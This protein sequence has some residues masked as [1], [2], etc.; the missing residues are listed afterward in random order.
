VPPVAS[1]VH[2]F[3][4]QGIDALSYEIEVDLCSG[5]LHGMAIVGLPDAAVRESA[6]R[7][8]TA[9]LASGYR[10]PWQRITVSLAP[11]DLRKEGPV[12]DLPIAVALLHAAGVV[13]EEAT[14]RMRELL[15]AGELALDGRLRPI[16]GSVSMALLA[17]RERRRGAVVP[18]A[19]GAEAAA[20]EGVEIHAM[21]TLSEVVALLNGPE[22]FEP[23][24]TIEAEALLR[25]AVAEIDFSEI[26]GQEAAKR[27]LT[28][29][30]AGAHNIL[31]I[32]PAGAG[33]TMMA[34]A[35]PGLLPPM[36]REEALEVTRIHSC[37]GCL[38]G[39]GS[40]VV[41]RPVRSPHHTASTAAIV[42]GGR[43]PRPGEVSL[44]HRG[45]LFL[46]ELPE[47]AR[48]V[49]EGLREPLEDGVVTIAR[50][51]GS[52]R[53][54][55]EVLLVAAMNPTQRGNRRAGAAGARE[56]ERY[57]SR[58]SGPLVDRVD[59]HVE[60]PAVPFEQL[61]GARQGATTETLRERVIGARQRAAARQGPDRPNSALRSRELDAVAPLDAASRSLLGEAMQQFGLSAR[62]YDKIRRVAR[63]IADLDGSESPRLEHVAEAVSYRLLDR[64]G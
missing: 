56:Q 37:A 17:R 34:R 18:L 52:V 2:S 59:L 11:S 48:P 21:G 50:A 57:L 60:V 33:K 44:A 29:A 12:F 58:L 7:V 8:R 27:A 64:E 49:L 53:F 9:I 24:P 41:R 38:E 54:P 19:N 39:G 46:D 43:V 15:L 51:H 14:P 31:L 42:G 32:G 3:V 35:L 25:T 22:A 10:F 47:F 16:R 26:R 28:I 4:L 36:S 63:T 62:A 45:V 40:L 1:R 20:V 30:A 55:A 13:G 6:E 23:V 5:G 61:A